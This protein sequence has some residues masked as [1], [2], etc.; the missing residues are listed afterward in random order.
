[1]KRSAQVHGKDLRSLH[2]FRQDYPEATASL[3]YLGRERLS[4]DGIPCIPCEEF[5]QALHPDQAAII[6]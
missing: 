3:L 1:V 2:A 6:P 4:I 5:L